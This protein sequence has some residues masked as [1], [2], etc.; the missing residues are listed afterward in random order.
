MNS[1]LLHQITKIISI[2]GKEIDVLKS[3]FKKKTLKVSEVLHSKGTVCNFE[4]FVQKGML[5]SYYTVENG[6]ERII[7]F[8]EE[9]QWVGDFDS[10]LS[11]SPSKFTIQALENC[12]LIIFSK[13]TINLLSNQISNWSI[14]REFFYKKIFIQKDKHTES[15][16]TSTPEQWYTNLLKNRPQLLN[17]VPQYFIA[18]YIGIQPES[19]SR[20]RKRIAK[21][22]FS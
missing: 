4:A 14:L 8:F 3:K 5:R 13:E 9:G 7:Q 6:T 17:R 22:N 2:T 18:Q 10:F 11:S 21:N 16:L 20:I 19:L 12:E 1:D 15:L